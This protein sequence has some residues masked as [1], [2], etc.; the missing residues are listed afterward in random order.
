MSYFFSQLLMYNY[1]RNKYAR[2]Y[3]NA[4]EIND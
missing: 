1:T 3:V 4:T 2:E